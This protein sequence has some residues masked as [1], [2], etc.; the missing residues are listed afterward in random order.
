M[1][2]ANEDVGMQ[3]LISWRKW[4]RWTELVLLFVG[5]PLVYAFGFK[6][7]PLFIVLTIAFVLCLLVLLFDKG[8]DK[9]ELYRFR[10][11]D[12]KLIFIRFGTAASL[13]AALVYFFLPEKFLHLFYEQPGLLAVIIVFYPIW[14]AYAQEVIYRAFFLQ[15]LCTTD[16]K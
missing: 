13:T 1:E 8:Y 4:Y 10:N 15:A 9:R 12:W 3:E 14:S 16:P 5:V 2:R 11:V 7:V 6:T